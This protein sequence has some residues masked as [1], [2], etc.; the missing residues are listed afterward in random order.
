MNDL[1]AEFALQPAALGNEIHGAQ[2]DQRQGKGDDKYN[3][4][5]QGELLVWFN[6]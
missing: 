5:I 3:V 6:S 2:E 4:V 1:A